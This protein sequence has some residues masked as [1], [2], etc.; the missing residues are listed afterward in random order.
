MSEYL[1]YYKVKL[2]VLSPVHIGS[3]TKIG[4]KEYIYMPWN[5]QV[6][7]PD[8][9]KMYAELQKKH[10]EKEFETYMLDTR[11]KGLALGKWL[12]THKFQSKDYDKWTLYQMDAGEAFANRESAPPKEIDT[13][14]KDAYGMPYVPG[15]SIK[16]MIRTALISWEIQRNPEK[17]EKIRQV[18]M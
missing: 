9:Q 3:G 14:V 2:H 12:S 5:H 1:K 6:I 4:K 18:I 7:I 13:F 8:I 15:S 10:L 16:G 11:T 17:Y